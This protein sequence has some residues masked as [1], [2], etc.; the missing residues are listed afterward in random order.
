VEARTKCV[1]FSPTGGQWAAAS[2]QGLLIYAL[3]DALVFDPLDLDLDVSEDNVLV[4]LRQKQWSAALQMALRLGLSEH[5]L[6]RQCAES[7]PRDAV[8]LSVQALPRR[9][10]QRLLAFLA[11][12]LNESPHLEFCLTWAYAT[13]LHHGK[14]LRANAH[15]YVTPLRALHKAV[16]RHQVGSITL[17]SVN[18]YSP[19][20]T[21]VASVNHY[22]PS[23]THVA[24]VNHYLP[25][26]TDV[27]SVNHYSPCLC[28][29]TLTL[30]AFCLPY[31]ADV[32]RMSQQNRY[33]LDYLCSKPP[34]PPPVVD[35]DD[36]IVVVGDGEV[37]GGK[38]EADEV[39]T[40]PPVAAKKKKSKKAAAPDVANDVGV[41]AVESKK[42]STK[43]SKKRKI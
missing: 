23:I 28:Y 1:R 43:K 10:L 11:T 14:H 20:I 27:A 12:L 5:T 9:L 7:T 19:S 40:P 6:L 30:H 42:K 2:T 33:L 21:H 41:D 24:S 18:H 35:D 3:D 17:A 38:D 25:S 15:L 31:Q 32:S 34:P 4:C 26:I 39:A 8:A 29:Q 16:R 22:S 36:E 37:G 13:L